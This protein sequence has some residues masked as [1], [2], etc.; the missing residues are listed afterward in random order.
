VNKNRTSLIKSLNISYRFMNN[1]QKTAALLRLREYLTSNDEA[2]QQVKVQASQVNG[3]FT[4]A[5]IDT[6]I[7]NICQY[8]LDETLLNNWLAAYPQPAG[9]LPKTVGITTAGNIPLVGF[10]DWLCGFV[11]G[12]HVKLKLSSKDT[13]LLQHLLQV[14]SSWYP[15][16][17]QQTTISEMLK[18][19]DAYIATGS[20]NSARYFEYYF[21][22]FPHIIRRNRTSAALLTGSETAAELE[23]LADDMMLYFGLGCRNVTKIFVPEGYD[24]T[25]LLQ[26]HERK[27]AYLMEHHK[28]RNNYDYNLALFLLNSSPY[29]TNGSLLVQEHKS[30]FSAISVLHYSYYEDAATLATSLLANPDLQCLVGRDFTPFGLAQQPSLT[31]YADGVDTLAFLRSL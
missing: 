20:N 1:T 31:D 6:A 24:F 23:A 8:Y 30:L 15:E 28:Y 5:F 29:L 21:S 10:H 19:C 13:L 17:A 12:H 14:M 27:Y 7:Q 26:A 3:W 2:L 11:S 18:D 4:P 25:P 9:Q 22:R 16:T